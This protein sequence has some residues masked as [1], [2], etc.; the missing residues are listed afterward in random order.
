MYS[1]AGSSGGLRKTLHNGQCFE[2]CSCRILFFGQMDLLSCNPK[3]PDL[4]KGTRV[5]RAL[6]YSQADLAT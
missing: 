6:S 1:C 3:I 2:I 5:L 4:N